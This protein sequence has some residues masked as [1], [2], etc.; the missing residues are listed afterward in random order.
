MKEIFVKRLQSCALLLLIVSVMWMTAGCA[1]PFDAAAY[2]QAVL[3]ASYKNQTEGYIEHTEVSKEE[4]DQIFQ[5]NLEETMEVFQSRE[6]PEELQ[7]N[8][9]ELFSE[10]IRQVHYTIGN[11]TEGDNGNYIVEVTV[12]P[13]L[14]FDD[15]YEEFQMKAEEYAADLTNEVMNG[16]E[17]PSDT[18]IQNQVYMLYYEI[19]NEAAASGLN[20][21][22]AVTVKMHVNQT[23]E[24]TYQIPEEDMVKL[25]E[26]MISRDKF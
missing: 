1:R 10:I 14:L 6:L 11:V 19:L 24:K 12:E 4:A 2:T 22:Q 15:T 21:G 18:E 17:M 9:K 26:K 16:K 8:Y 13:I 5:K 3:D 7:K 23:D 20:Y 25:A